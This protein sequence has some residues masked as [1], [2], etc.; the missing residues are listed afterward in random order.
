MHEKTLSVLMQCLV[1]FSLD[2]LLNVFTGKLSSEQIKAGYAALKD[3]EKFIKSNKFSSGFI[4]ANNTY[5]TRSIL[6]T[7]SLTNRSNLCFS[8]SD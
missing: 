7:I 5:Y 3:I 1:G 8:S 4:E 2:P 6:R